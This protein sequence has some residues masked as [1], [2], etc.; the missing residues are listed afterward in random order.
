MKIY[1]F[2]KMNYMN[3]FVIVKVLFFFSKGKV[4]FY[5]KV[6]KLR[7]IKRLVILFIVLGKEGYSVCWY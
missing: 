6:L 2:Y 4:F 7:V 1:L 3:E 5:F